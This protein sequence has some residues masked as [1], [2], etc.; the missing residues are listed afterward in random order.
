[1]GFEKLKLDESFMLRRGCV[2]EKVV[3]PAR[4]YGRWI[5]HGTKTLA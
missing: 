2:L 5:G 3:Y 4:L 1:M